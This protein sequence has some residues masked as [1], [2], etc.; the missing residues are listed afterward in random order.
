MIKIKQPSVST[1]ILSELYPGDAFVTIGE[2]QKGIVCG[3]LPEIKIVVEKLYEPSTCKVNRVKVLI[4]QKDTPASFEFVNEV[5]DVVIR[6]N[7]EEVEVSFQS[8]VS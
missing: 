4:L 3:E 6:V 2:Y 5:T 7:I 8:T 1:D